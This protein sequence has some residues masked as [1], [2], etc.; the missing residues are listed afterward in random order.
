MDYHFENTHEFIERKK[1]DVMKRISRLISLL[2]LLFTSALLHAQGANGQSA[3]GSTMRSE[4]R[5]Y[6][7]IAVILTILAGLILYVVRLDRKLK[8][9]EK[10]S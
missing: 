5:I 1:D 2:L 10:D 4:G 3:F 9:L 6:V 8:K 7:V